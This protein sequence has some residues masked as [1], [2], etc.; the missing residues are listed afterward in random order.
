MTGDGFDDR[1]PD[2]GFDDDAFDDETGPDGPELG[3]HRRA[4]RW[5]AVGSI[6]LALVWLLGLASMVAVFVG[7]SSRLELSRFSDP[8]SRRFRVVADVGIA[9]GML[10]MLLGFFVALDV[11]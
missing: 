6:G 3:D 10:G 11:V 4:A 5:W 8:G 1:F 2:D 9:L 7:L